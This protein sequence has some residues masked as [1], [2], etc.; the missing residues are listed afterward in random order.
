VLSAQNA[1]LVLKSDKLEFERGAAAETENE[2]RYNGRENR[3]HDRNGTAGSWKSPASLS[4][5]EILSKDSDLFRLIW[6]LLRSRLIALKPGMTDLISAEIANG[7]Y[8]K[9]L[10]TIAKEFQ[11]EP[12]P[13]EVRE[14]VIAA[15]S[16]VG[17][18]PRAAIEEMVPV[19]REAH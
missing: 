16:R 17:L 18:L 7:M 8:K 1:Q 2:D 5:V 15:W 19:V 6:C 9:P 11:Y 10:D 14:A 12:L 4:P 13:T 3:H